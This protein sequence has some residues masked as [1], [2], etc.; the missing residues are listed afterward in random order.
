M[1]SRRELYGK[2][3]TELLRVVTTYRCLL[4]GQLY[5]LFPAREGAAHKMLVHLQRQRRITLNSETGLCAAGK[6]EPDAGMIAAFWVLL[7][8][9]DKAEYHTSGD[10]PVQI[11]YFADGEAV[12]IIYAAAGQE[13]L[14]SHALSCG[15]DPPRRLVIVDAPDRTAGIHI[16]NIAGFCIVAPDGAV[17][18]Y[19]QHNNEG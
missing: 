8:F 2:E 9:L 10:F 1:I 18:Y 11:C 13:A 7:D 19:K 15:D 14:V 12:E 6:Q 4:A 3:A 17:T 5:R 16:P